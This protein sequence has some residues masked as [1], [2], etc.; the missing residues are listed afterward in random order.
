MAY[1]LSAPPS[2]SL[3]S[4]TSLFFTSLSPP[5]LPHLKTLKNLNFPPNLH[6]PKPSF[7]ISA[8]L[9]LQEPLLNSIPQDSEI[10]TQKAVSPSKSFVWVNPKN[11]NA[12]KLMQKSHNSIRYASLPQIA[13]SL[14]SCAPLDDAV[15]GVLDVLGDKIEEKVAVV[16][17]NNM[18]NSETAPLVLDYFLK[19]LKVIREVVLYNVTLKVFRK[20]KDLGK[21]EGLF[22][23]MLERGVKPDNFTFSTIISCT[24]M[25]S[26]P[27]KAVE[28][29]E[30][31]SLFGC[32]PDKVTCSV[33]IDV[34][35]RVGNVAVALSMYDRARSEKWRLDPVTFSTLIRIYREEGNYD[36]C[37]N[38]YEEMKALGVKANASVYNA[39]LDAMGKAK[40]PWQAKTIY[41]QM[42]KNGVE[43]TWGTYAALIRAYGR[44]RYGIDAIAVYK[45]MKENGLEMSV[46]LYNTLLSACADVGFTDEAAEIFEDM[47]SSGTCKP[48]SW[49]YASLI[50]INSCSGKVEEAE[51]TLK[52]M[53]EAGFQANIFILTSMI[54]CYGK[55]GRIDDVVR[56]FDQ[57][58]DSGI[59]PDARFSGSL[60]NVMTQAPK[61]ELGKL[62]A[63]IEK[64]HPKLGYIVNLVID[65]E[66][67]DGEIFRKEVGELLQSIGTDVK[68]VYCNCLID[69]CVSLNQLE[70]A[71]ELLDLGLSLEIYTDIMSR[72]PTQWSLHLKSLSLGAALTALHVW[73]KD[74]SKALENGEEFPELLGINTGHG[75]HKFSER[76][77]AGTFEPHLKE[78]EAPFHETPDKIGWF[79]TTKAAAMSWLQSR[80][81]ATY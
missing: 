61:E 79:L 23:L 77:L 60:L 29:F 2:S 56:T 69:L 38:L 48:D 7:H 1:N 8:E 6:R 17:L 32:E 4:E 67:T 10:P 76:G 59:V 37:L 51:A 45:E 81:S 18:S 50:T 65:E 52:E 31:M 58:L 46:L 16:I 3:F 28:W 35:G 43:P 80:Q 68:K 5:K 72:T 44:A 21:A 64:A 53:L 66:T 13:E 54:Q 33:M 62:K 15:S 49:T 75:K 22:S 74:L 36:G 40:R 14:N 19:R 73:V 63:C 57:M 20:C 26:L 30:K 11:P 71:C 78:L 12:S 41:R 47:K 55:A 39:L 70:R 42:V 34:Y 25:S 9:S 27:E 24:R